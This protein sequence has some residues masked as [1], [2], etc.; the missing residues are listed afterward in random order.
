MMVRLSLKLSV[1]LAFPTIESGL[2]CDIV[3][4][5]RT[6]WVYERLESKRQSNEQSRSLE[7][8]DV[9]AR[10]CLW[11]NVSDWLGR[12]AQGKAQISS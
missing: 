6:I 11:S 7:S 9:V 12:P 1:S 2:T 4:A 8:S 5:S 3:R 10:R